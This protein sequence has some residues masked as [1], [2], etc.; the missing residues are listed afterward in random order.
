MHF[1]LE[2]TFVL[3]L[4]QQLNETIDDF[5]FILNNRRRSNWYNLILENVLT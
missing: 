5:S 2:L 4:K 1:S 3:V